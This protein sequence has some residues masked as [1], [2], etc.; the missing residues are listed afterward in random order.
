MS[1]ITKWFVSYAYIKPGSKSETSSTTIVQAE[2][3]RTAIRLVEDKHPECKTIIK[4]I[5]RK[6]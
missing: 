5:D 2:T 4:R 3:E 1:N 6:N